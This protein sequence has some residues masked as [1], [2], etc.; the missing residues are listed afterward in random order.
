MMYHGYGMGMGWAL[1]AFAVV[2]PTLLGALWLLITQLQRSP[3][4]PAA[5]DPLPGAER[6]LADRLARGEID[7]DEYAQRLRALRAERC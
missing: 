7:T 6:I 3:E 4:V 1:I 2:V 5:S